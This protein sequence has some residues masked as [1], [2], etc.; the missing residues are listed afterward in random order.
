MVR[1]KLVGFTVDYL[2]LLEEKSDL[3]FE[4]VSDSWE[5]SIS[6]FRAGQLDAITALSYT[7]ERT[8]FTRYTDPYYRIPTVVYTRDGA[9]EYGGV[10]DLRGKTVAIEA[11]VFYKEYLQEYPDIII[12]EIEDTG[13][14]MQALAFGEVDAV[15]TNVNI[16]DYMIKRNM[17]DNVSVAGGIDI[18][19]I[20]DEDLR[21]GVR[22]ELPEIHAAVQT[23]MNQVTPLEYNELQ[24]RWVGF[25]IKEIT[26]ALTPRERAAIGQYVEA[27]GG[28]RI[29]GY[30]HL[31][32]VEF[33]DPAG[34]HSGIVADLFG[35]VSERLDVPFINEPRESIDGAVAAVL[36][37]AADLIPA[38]EPTAMLRERLSFSKP[39]LS[40]PLVIATRNS[41]FFIGDPGGLD[42]RNVAILAAGPLRRI[43]Q[44]KYPEMNLRPVDSAEEGLQ[45]VQDGVDFAFI[46][47]TP[48]IA[49]AIQAHGFFNIKISGRLEE[50]RTFSVAVAPGN[51]ELLRAMETALL[52]LDEDDRRKAVERWISVSLEERV[53][54]RTIWHIVFIV[55]TIAVFVGFWL[56]AVHRYNAR[57][58]RA[59]KLLED[60]NQELEVLSVT[61]Q[62][63]GLFNR[64]KLD[65]EL[66]REIERA[67][68][69]DRPLTIMLLDIDEFKSVNDRFGHQRGDRI[70]V[71]VADAIRARVRGADIA[72]RWGGEEFMVICTETERTGAVELGEML[73]SDIADTDFGIGESM[74]VSVGVA[75]SKPGDD[76]D[77]ILHRADTRLYEAKE[78]G[79]NRG[80]LHRRRGT[81]QAGDNRRI[82]RPDCG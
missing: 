39:Y 59:Y 38:L 46:G 71:G 15:V 37:G 21:I 3:E 33:I 58:S 27:Y 64:G 31:Y 78:R 20:A 57:L 53:D 75:Q 60:K 12:R 69:Y 81:Y 4:L 26:D 14:L 70:L 47:T 62:L 5:N 65:V 16:G 29:A 45:R 28:V 25:E 30:Q 50:K 76:A 48:E 17:L 41:E 35:A 74:T 52:A 54:T 66:D 63:T 51:E 1:G 7:E 80:T 32:P 67:Q 8:A 82:L 56:H 13:E 9:F 43:I 55:V 61:N 23:A 40:L 73:R 19:E 11:G 72:G 10:E 68:R 2:R 18:D 79:K 49:H 77:S 6:K 22:K 42:R 24:D 44:E 34:N 36:G